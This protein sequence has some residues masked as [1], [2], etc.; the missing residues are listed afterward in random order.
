MARATMGATRLYNI[1][2]EKLEMNQS[3]WQG[4][5]WRQIQLRTLTETLMQ[6][7]GY[8]WTLGVREGFQL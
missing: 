3:I 5:I 1:S 7:S 2:S 4:K 8:D 6:V